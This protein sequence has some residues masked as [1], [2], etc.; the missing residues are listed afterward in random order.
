VVGSVILHK[1]SDAVHTV[2]LKFKQDNEQRALALRNGETISTEVQ[3]RRAIA[4]LGVMEQMD[5]KRLW[6]V[7]MPGS[8]PIVDSVS[9][10]LRQYLE[11]AFGDIAAATLQRALH[12]RVSQ[13][14]GVRKTTAPEN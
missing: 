7:F 3:N 5:G 9:D 12:T 2:L 14:T 6:S 8:W 1:Q 4:L 11:Q 13:L 10:D